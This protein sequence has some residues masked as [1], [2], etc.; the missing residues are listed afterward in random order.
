MRTT[1]YQILRQFSTIHM[2]PHILKKSEFSDTYQIV[3]E[4]DAK[5]IYTIS[6]CS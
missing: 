5:D 2:G 6:D 1:Q 3:L 4:E